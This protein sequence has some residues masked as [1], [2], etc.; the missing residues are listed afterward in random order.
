MIYD[1]NSRIQKHSLGTVPD[2][3][4]FIHTGMQEGEDMTILSDEKS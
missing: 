3:H 2:H 4:C 1:T